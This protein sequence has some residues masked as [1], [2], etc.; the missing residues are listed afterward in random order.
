[1]VEPTHNKVVLMRT[2]ARGVCVKII[3]IIKITRMMMMKITL[4]N[5]EKRYLVFSV[6]FAILLFFLALL[7]IFMPLLLSILVSVSLPYQGI[8]NFPKSAP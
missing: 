1:M 7:L 8:G 4:Y 6:F 3:I 2:R 5:I